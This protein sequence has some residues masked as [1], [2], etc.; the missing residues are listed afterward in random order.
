MLVKLP[1]VGNKKRRKLAAVSAVLGMII[2]IGLTAA[3]GGGVYYTFQEQADLF[4]SSSQLE[5]K[6]F[7]A[8]RTDDTL[9]ISANIKNIGSTAVGDMT[10]G[11][12]ISGNN[13]AFERTGENSD[14]DGIYTIKAH[15]GFVVVTK[16]DVILKGGKLHSSDGGTEVMTGLSKITPDDDEPDGP[17]V[18]ISGLKQIDGGS[19]IAMNITFEYPGPNPS[20]PLLSKTVKVSD[21]LIFQLSYTS[22]TD[23]FVSDV[24]N[25]RIRP[26]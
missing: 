26:G 4:S 14:G 20:S 10:V 7:N 22:G 21:R 13:F 23:E 11:S 25:T 16:E 2:A 15:D 19:T 24:Y 17:A 18:T 9:R 8:I 1:I 5:V 12:I 6:N 3:V